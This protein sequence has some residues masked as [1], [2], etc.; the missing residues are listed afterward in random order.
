MGTKQEAL[1]STLGPDYDLSKIPQNSWLETFGFIVASVR[2][3][4]LPHRRRTRSQ[5]RLL[6]PDK[7]WDTRLQLHQFLDND[8][9]RNIY[10]TSTIFLPFNKFVRKSL[11]IKSSEERSISK[12]NKAVE[13]GNSLRNAI[14]SE[15]AG[16]W[17]NPQWRQLVLSYQE[18]VGMLEKIAHLRFRHE[19]LNQVYSCYL[20]LKSRPR[21]N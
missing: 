18:K 13:A 16:R 12:F 14:L 19:Y 5:P 17:P 8:M 15:E 10:Y 2:V 4:V 9:T 6:I 11:C 7:E 3:V 1:E 20:V 21:V